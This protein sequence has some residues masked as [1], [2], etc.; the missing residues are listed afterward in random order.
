M[1]E[2]VDNN[3][4]YKIDEIVWGKVCGYPWWPGVIISFSEK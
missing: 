3:C 2:D 4:T 1:Q